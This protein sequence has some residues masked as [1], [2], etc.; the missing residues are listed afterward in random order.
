[1]TI[2]VNM[3]SMDEREEKIIEAAISVFSRYGVKRTTMNDIASEAGIARQTLY[4]A[5]SNKDEVL[6]A[7]IRWHSDHSLAAIE[8]E[9]ADV[10]ALGDKLDIVFRRLAIE[11]FVQL[12]ASPHASD[13][14]SGFNAAAQDEISIANERYRAAIERVL[15]PQE[16]Q[17]QSAG[18]SL[19]Q[20]SDLVQN[21][22]AA[23]K[24]GAKNKKHL[25]DL[26]A[27]LK[28]QVLAVA[29]VA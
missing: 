27:S 3:S 8:A 14:I 15:A 1:M 10:P 11:P 6:R 16:P 26:L 21:S 13:I 12:R 18:L 29:D 20:L 19:Y 2:N 7:T 24:H 17:I 22:V 9:C 28:I 25:L 23:F 5:F 4:N